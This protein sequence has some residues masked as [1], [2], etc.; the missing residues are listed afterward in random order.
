MITPKLGYKMEKLWYSLF[1]NCSQSSPSNTSQTWGGCS[2]QTCSTGYG[3]CNI[4]THVKC[5]QYGAFTCKTCLKQARDSI[6]DAILN[7]LFSI[8]YSRRNRKLRIK[9]R[10]ENRNGLSTYFWTV[11]YILF[12]TRTLQKMAKKLQWAFQVIHTML[13]VD[14]WQKQT[15][16]YLW[17]I[18]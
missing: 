15:E 4:Y 5:V 17:L 12:P 6:L 13:A 16:K 8:L 3:N 7:S 10:I 14:C 1:Y 18:R 2:I 11:L 9:S